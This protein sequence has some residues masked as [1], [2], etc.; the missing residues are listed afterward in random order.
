MAV[1]FD[2]DGADVNPQLVHPVLCRARFVGGSDAFELL[3]VGLAF[4]VLHDDEV[5]DVHEH[6]VD[7]RGAG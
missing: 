7:V 1:I 2:F 4:R 3:G 5:V 6:V